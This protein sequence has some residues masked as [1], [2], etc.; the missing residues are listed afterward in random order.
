MTFIRQLILVS[1][2][3]INLSFINMLMNFLG[4]YLTLIIIFTL[5]D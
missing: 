5:I 4:S 1:A 3:E 2:F